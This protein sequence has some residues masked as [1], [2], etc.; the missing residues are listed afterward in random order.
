[1]H[2]LPCLLTSSNIYQNISKNEKVK[3]K[4]LFQ[5]IRIILIFFTFGFI[6]KTTDRL[7]ILQQKLL[8]P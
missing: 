6:Y 1:M 2:L 3:N 8:N 7:T 4:C 5:F